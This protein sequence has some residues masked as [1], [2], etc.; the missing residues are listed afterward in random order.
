MNF[1]AGYVAIV[2]YPNAGKSSLL[3]RLIG[4]KIS[5]VTRKPQTTRQRITGLLNV[6]GGQAVFV[7]TPGVLDPKNSLHKFLVE[8]VSS[9]VRECDL[10]VG[11]VEWGEKP[12]RVQKLKEKLEQFGA[13]QVLWVVN[14]IDLRKFESTWV[15]DTKVNFDFEVS[16]LQST[17]KDLDQ[18]KQM[19]VERLPTSP[20]PLYDPESLTTA[21]SREIVGEMIREKCLDFL[22]DEIPYRLAVKVQKFEEVRKP[23]LIAA[24][25]VLDKP[26]HKGIVLGQKGSM[27]KQIGTES[28]KA[29]E[30]L[31]GEKVFLELHVV[32]K[33]DWMDNKQ[34]MQELGYGS[35]LKTNENINGEQSSALGNR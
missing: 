24:D 20:A 14:K 35:R 26:S 25:I 13:R 19:I 10:V 12:E 1:K 6:T 16:S 11:L 31:L 23:V 9:S 7:D 3:N 5:I 30:S 15:F 27:I 28:R 4:E 8:E 22:D 18:L 17:D 32:V 29:I 2:G 21:T 34:K 33:P